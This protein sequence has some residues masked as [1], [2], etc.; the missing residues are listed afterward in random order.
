VTVEVVPDKLINLALAG[1][2]E[3]LKLVHCLKFDDI[4]TVWQHAIGFSF[5]KVLGLVG[6]DMQYGST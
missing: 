2:V 3:V 5:E 6:G 4:E 1:G